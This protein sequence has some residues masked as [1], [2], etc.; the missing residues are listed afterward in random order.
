MYS[1]V[2]DFLYHISEGYENISEG[3]ENISER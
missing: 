3:Y 1:L 2:W